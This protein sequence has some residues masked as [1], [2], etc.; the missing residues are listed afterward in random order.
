MT[1]E[2]GRKQ[3]AAFKARR[4]APVT[5]GRSLSKLLRRY[6]AGAFER[7]F[8]LLLRLRKLDPLTTPLAAT[9]AAQ[10]RPNTHDLDRTLGERSQCQ[11]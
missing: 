1:E 5:V 8:R 10:G 9:A 11:F 4:E 2:K 7:A 6:Q 3:P